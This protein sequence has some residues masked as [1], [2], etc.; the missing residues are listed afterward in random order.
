ME[1]LTGIEPAR[2]AWEAKVLPLNYSCV[3]YIIQP[4]L[5]MYSILFQK[6]SFFNFPEEID[7]NNDGRT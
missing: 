5:G 6:K 4:F 3:S 2:L 7:T 1:Q